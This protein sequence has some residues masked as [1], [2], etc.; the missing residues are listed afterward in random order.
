MLRKIC[1]ITLLLLVI[2]PIMAKSNEVLLSFKVNSQDDVNKLSSLISIDKVI[3][4]VVYA[5]A[6]QKQLSK[7]AQLNYNY[8]IIPKPDRT[9][10]PMASSITEMRSWDTYPTYET[11]VNLMYQFATDHPNICTVTS[12]GQSV[13]GREILVANISDNPGIEEDEPEFFYTGQM[14]GNE[15]VSFIMLIQLIDYLTDNYGTNDRITNI[16]DNIE[17]FI[18]PLS[19]PDGTYA[20]GNDTVWDATR[21]NSNSVD[22]NR[23]FPD[24]EDGPHPDGNEWQPENIVMMN[25][26][27]E[28]T[29]VLSSNFHSGI[30]V[31]NYPWDTWEHLTAD[32]EW[33]QEVCHTYAD[34]V[35]LYAP[36]GYMDEFNNGITNGYQWYSISGGRQD[37]MN[38]FHRCRE[39]TLELADE[40]YLPE[41]QL[42][43]HWNYNRQ[44]FLL[45]MEECLYGLKGVVTDSSGEPL[46]AK[47][48]MVGHDIDN[49]EVFTDPDVG[50]YHRMLK[51]GVYNAEYDA[52]GY[53]PHTVPNIQISDNDVVFQDVQLQSKPHYTISGLITN[54]FNSDPI[55]NAEVEVLNTPLEP[56]L[57]DENGEFEISGVYEDSYELQISAYGFSTLLQAITV[58]AS[59]TVFDLELYECDTENFET[60]DFTFLPW[61]FSGNTDWTIDPINFFDGNYSAR[62][63]VITHNEETSLSINITTSY[64]GYL[65]FYKK[66]SSEAGYDMLNFYIDEVAVDSWS[67]EL[68]WEFIS[69]FVEE[70]DHTFRWSYEKDASVSNGNDCG[71][72]D[73]ISFPPTQVL[74]ASHENILHKIELVG[75]FPNPFNPETEIMFQLSGAM[76]VEL[77]IYN[78]KGQKVRTLIKE[79]KEAGIHSIVWNGT[80]NDNK[81]VA[82]GIYFYRMITD[83]V[84]E[85]KKML[86]LK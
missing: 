45:Y 83:E 9:Y 17:I 6:N 65:S 42:I 47:V 2:I 21:N 37:Y 67:G 84:T 53:F 66:V 1:V 64:D 73:M 63:G 27:E 72:L 55:E 25:F 49:S 10:E 14:H 8:T 57:T 22:L 69:Y 18:N 62:S 75:N 36:T 85:S 12:I 76:P 32:D 30:E 60:G 23:N 19:N 5:Y 26:A 74:H 3:G 4:N 33:W 7:F 59:N 48:T 20:G 24:P 40:K 41:N 46:L 68:D 79:E 16:V 70:G 15:L 61:E 31:L 11:Y 82:S 71:W 35:H 56:V 51:P 58:N 39:M 28:H 80:D 29:F 86:L 77:S 81:S 50:D 52:W 38:Y 43:P 54:F 44:S 78:I 13:E 34:T